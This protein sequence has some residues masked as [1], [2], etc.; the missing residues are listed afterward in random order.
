MDIRQLTYFVYTYQSRSFSAAAKQCCVTV[1]TVS[2]AIGNLE[3]ELHDEA[4]F[5]RKNNGVVPTDFGRAFYPRALHALEVFKQAQGFADEYQE[6]QKQGR[7]LSLLIC[8]PPFPHSEQVC[9]N[10]SKLFAFVARRN[11]VRVQT[12]IGAFAESITSLE[13]ETTDIVVTLGKPETTKFDVVQVGT[14]PTAVVMTE[15]HPLASSET[16][17]AQDLKQYPIIG[18]QDFD[19]ER[20]GSIINVYKQKG[21]DLSLHYPTTLFSLVGE[22]YKNNGLSLVV[23]IPAIVPSNIGLIMKPIDPEDMISLPICLVTR[24]GEKP[25]GYEPIKLFLLNGGLAQG[26]SSIK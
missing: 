18:S 5:V 4:L 9:A 24:K 23:D 21:L 6:Q 22:Y 1:Q 15:I 3:H 11:N 16:I 19:R 17:T 10:V 14:V 13:E 20:T 8:T 12:E 26:F 25:A 2:K 7:V